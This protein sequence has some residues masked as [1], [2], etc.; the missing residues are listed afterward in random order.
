MLILSR[1]LSVCMP[2]RF[3][4]KQ[5]NKCCMTGNTKAASDLNKQLL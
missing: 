5:K 3:I 2:I 1:Q 4:T